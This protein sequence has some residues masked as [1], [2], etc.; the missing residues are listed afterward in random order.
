MFGAHLGG[1]GLRS[2]QK[3][4]EAWN[5]GESVHYVDHTDRYDR[6]LAPFS[7]ALLAR[8][9]LESHHAVLDIGCGCGATT[10]RAA[11][12]VQRAVGADLSEPLLEIA[13]HRARA[14]GVANAQFVIADAQ[15]HPFEAGAFDA[16]IS[17]FGVM[18]FDAPIAAFVNLRRALAP[19]GR[20]AFVCWQGLQANEWL[21]V[22]GRVVSQYVVLPQF[23]GQ[24]GGPGMFSLCDPSEITTLLQSAGF[25]Q[26][27]CD[28]LT[29]TILVGG[30]G[31]LDES[32]DFLLGM[33]MARGLIG[34][35]GP[36]AH[37][38]VIDSVRRELAE[39]YEPNIGLRLGT[40]AW[41]VSART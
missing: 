5:G 11:A 18:F 29:P 37:D 14:S 32:I 1:L 34:L 4:F 19:G 36:D 12:L 8:G 26:V 2:N 15:T 13:R 25:E 38:A 40:A 3:Q 39:R 22:L 30:G 6:Q 28:P 24:S 41:L 33:G 20:A 9:G 27:E 35:A 10:L 21:M 23:G 16:I 31:T 17:Q 7:E